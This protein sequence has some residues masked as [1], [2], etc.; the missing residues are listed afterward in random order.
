M[1]ALKK[2]YSEKITNLCR[3]LIAVKEGNQ[4][5]ATDYLSYAIAYTFVDLSGYL[6]CLDRYF[7]TKE[8]AVA[9]GFNPEFIACIAW[10]PATKQYALYFNIEN[11][12]RLSDKT[13]Y[14]ILLHE[15]KHFVYAHP[16]SMFAIPAKD[17]YLMNVAQ[18]MK[19]NTEL[20]YE[21]VESFTNLDDPSNFVD[22]PLQ[23]AQGKFFFNAFRIDQ[24]SIFAH[25]DLSAFYLHPNSKLLASKDG[26]RKGIYDVTTN[27][28]FAWLKNSP[29]YQE[30]IEK[31]EKKEINQL[32]MDMILDDSDIS[33]EDKKERID[34][35]QKQIT[36]ISEINTTPFLSSDKS[37]KFDTKN[38]QVKAYE[39]DATLFIKS[40]VRP[41]K[42]NKVGVSWASYNVVLP[43]LLPGPRKAD[44]PL[45]ACI[46]DT[47]GSI[48]ANLAEKFVSYLRKL[49]TF[50]SVHYIMNDSEVRGDLE[51]A[52]NKNFAETIEWKGGGCTD[53]NPALKIIGKYNGRY[54]YDAVLCFTDGII[55]EIQQELVPDNFYLILPSNYKKFAKSEFL[56]RYNKL[57]L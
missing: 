28:I 37:D 52:R 23:N 50:A 17:R 41:G 36:K 31:Q 46:F 24:E 30:F 27:E 48:D 43:E 4:N 25:P 6:I 55:P 7:L 35:I 26:P 20:L 5:L 10:T 16:V 38:I 3:A 51:K 15:L 13:F 33:E 34:S 54:K 21:Y 14:F 18:D 11:I 9:E 12:S 42:R 39:G 57:L 8:E 22:Y 2:I 1:K 32:S 53:L 44:K 47:S 56:E 45:I 40:L 29:D 49:A 19:I